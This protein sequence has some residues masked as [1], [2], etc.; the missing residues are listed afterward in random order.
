MT[1]WNLKMMTSYVLPLQARSELRF[2][3]GTEV[4]EVQNPKQLSV[5]NLGIEEKYC[6]F[7]I[8]LEKWTKS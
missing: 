4:D 2:W 6:Q 1:P 5:I 3:R 7:F 8:T